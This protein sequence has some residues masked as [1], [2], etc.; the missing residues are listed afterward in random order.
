MS[1]DRLQPL[2]PPAIG[3]DLLSRA[4]CSH[5][6]LLRLSAPMVRGKRWQT[7]EVGPAPTVNAAPRPWRRAYREHRLPRR[8]L[9]QVLTPWDL[10]LPALHPPLELDT[11]AHFDLPS[12]LYAYQVDGVRFLCQSHAALLA[13]EMG[14]GKTVMGTVAM[15]VLFR[16]GAVRCA[17]VVAPL[18]VLRVWDSHLR[19]WAPEL[20][21]TVVHGSQRRRATDW[22]CPAHVYLTTYDVLRADVLPATRGAEP[23]M[24]LSRRATLDLVMLDEAQSIK[25]PESGRTRAVRRLDPS[26]RWA[27][28]GTPVEN[29]L[30]DLQSIF[31]FVQPRLLPRDGLRPQE[32]AALIAPLV[33]RR[34][35]AE[36]MRD[37]PPKIRQDIWLGLDAAQRAAYGAA[38]AE[39]RAALASLGDR[40]SKVHVFS[41]IT[42]LK[43]ICNFAPGATDSPK[44]R[45][46]LEMVEEIRS[47]GQKVLVFTQWV[48]EGI[49]KLVEPLRRFGVVPFDARL[50]RE[51]RDAAIERFRTDPA[52][53]V[54]LA[55]VK[56]A[57]VG[58][59][60]TE[61]SYVVH[62]DHWWNPA[63]MWQAEDRAHRRGQT[64]PVNVYSLWMEDTLEQRIHAILA[65][66][67]ALHEEVVD[68]LSETAI[69]ELI[70]L[71]EWI[72]LFGMGG[73]R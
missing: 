9:R 2:A 11:S 4:R 17:L 36:V 57:G 43:L 25:N 44:L 19:E 22:R 1:R 37:L 15:R 53:G 23:N 5:D 28:S 33:K 41:L 49:D 18:S 66:K 16:R 51:Q 35:K 68:G 64:Q 10:L 62:F 71:D 14:T 8:V 40:L 52:A 55:T 39:G 69:D 27:L 70:S 72:T 56:S 32:A 12:Q 47:S 20:E 58:L 60:L 38:E 45:A 63:W 65:K 59:T 6:L 46:L 7:P 30:G 73:R 50:S 3:D 61:A 42:Q 13:D 24:P 31:A 54:F 29:R 48:R 26:Y 67:G 21:V 34:T